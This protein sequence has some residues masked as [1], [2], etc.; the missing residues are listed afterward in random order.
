MWRNKAGG[1]KIY[2]QVESFGDAEARIWVATREDVPGLATEADRLEA[3]IAKL[4]Q[5]IP[6]LMSLN[7]VV[8]DMCKCG[9]IIVES[10][11]NIS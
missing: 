5:M 10:D 3:L 2:C 11:N 8:P 7:Q 4:R 1:S 6:E 9:C